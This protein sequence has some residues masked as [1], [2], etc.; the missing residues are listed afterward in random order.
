MAKEKTLK[1]W[2]PIAQDHFKNYRS[3]SFEA[4]YKE[5]RLC[6]VKQYYFSDKWV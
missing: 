5:I 2:I 6:T 4:K 3:N 1:A